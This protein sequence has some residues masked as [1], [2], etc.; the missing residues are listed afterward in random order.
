MMIL[1]ERDRRI[2][3]LCYEQQFV[4]TEHV[5]AFFS[6]SYRA[7]RKRIQELVD[8]LYLHEELT[9][10]LGKKRIYRVTKLG[11]QVALETHACPV[12]QARVLQPA[13]L[14]HDAI[15]TSVR[16]RLE[17]FWNAQFICERAIKGKEY[18][19]IP[20]GLFVFP[21]G[22]AIAIEVENSDKGRS[23][24]SQNLNRWRD[25]QNVLFVLFIATNDSLS[26][27]I[28][29]CLGNA[30]QGRPMGVVRWQELES[31]VPLVWTRRGEIQLFER[32][33]F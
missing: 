27:S 5:E 24:F 4:L 11:A 10:A 3:R 19:Q 14:V 12:G 26:H 15:V 17:S 20:D 29:T 28:Q 23:R 30:P 2:L 1:Q 9:S 22:K 32:R 31:G 18:R 33:E 13:T 16:I 25:T 6:G 7:C 8:S 21:S